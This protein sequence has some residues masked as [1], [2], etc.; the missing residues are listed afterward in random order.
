MLSCSTENHLGCSGKAGMFYISIN[1]RYL[2][3]IQSMG[4]L[5]LEHTHTHFYKK[6]KKTTF[7]YYIF[8]S[9]LQMRTSQRE[10]FGDFVH[11]RKHIHI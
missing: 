4:A 3:Q 2:K 6:K 9:D 10:V 5:I 7:N 8:I 1:R 11:T